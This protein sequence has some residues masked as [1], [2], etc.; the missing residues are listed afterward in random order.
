MET[1][2]KTMEGYTTA[3]DVPMKP[4]VIADA[5]NRHL[6]DDAIVTCD[7]GTIATWWARHIR[8]KRGQMHSL[9]GTLASMANGLP[10]AIAAQVAHPERQVVAFVGDGGFS[11]L[12]AEFATAVKYRLPIKVVIV[13]N[14]TLGM[15]KW[16]Q[17]VFL[18][19]PEYGCELQPIDFA[20]FAR[21]CGGAGFSVADPKDVNGV[22]DEAFA[23]AGPVIVEATVD[24][25]E[26]PMPPK[27]SIDQAAKFAESLAKGAP[28]RK[29]IALTVLADKVRELV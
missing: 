4:Q 29:K 2:W 12:M 11:M 9:S 16:E 24:P 3:P 5:V 28:N 1:W 18:G 17:M 14:N 19:N 8:V 27:I 22:L 10:Y 25:F 20:A 26:P 7:S 15:I 13:K 6:R 23:T 21:A